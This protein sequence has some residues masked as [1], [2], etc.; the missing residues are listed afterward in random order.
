VC[1]C[2]NVLANFD[3]IR[4]SIS[5]FIAI[6]MMTESEQRVCSIQQQQQQQQQQQEKFSRY[7]T[8]ID[9][10]LFDPNEEKK[11]VRTRETFECILYLINFII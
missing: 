9:I 7:T 10:R 1:V 2:V 3:S 6:I 11:K 5:T 8:N 4:Y